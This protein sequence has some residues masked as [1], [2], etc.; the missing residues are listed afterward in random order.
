MDEVVEHV[1]S[2]MRFF[3]WHHVTSSIHNVVDQVIL[4]FCHPA[5]QGLEWVVNWSLACSHFP[6]DLLQVFFGFQVGANGIDISRIEHHLEI[7]LLESVKEGNCGGA[8]LISL[9]NIVRTGGPVGLLNVELLLD[10]RVIHKLDQTGIIS[11][12]VRFIIIG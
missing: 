5:F 2:C 7:G 3:T 11:I 4:V 6:S 1:V 8:P 9:A 12:T 10:F